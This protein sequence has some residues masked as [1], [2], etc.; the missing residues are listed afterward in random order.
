MQE[1]KGHLLFTALQKNLALILLE[2][3]FFLKLRD[4]GLHIKLESNY[5]HNTADAGNEENDNAPDKEEGR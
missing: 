1:K 2:Q 3:K 4:L 5:C